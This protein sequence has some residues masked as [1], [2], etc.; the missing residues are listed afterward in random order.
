MHTP[1]SVILKR[2]RVLSDLEVEETEYTRNLI[3]GP[4]QAWEALSDDALTATFEPSPCAAA[5]EAFLT[6][7][8]Q[9]YLGA[10]TCL[11]TAGAMV[12]LRKVCGL[13]TCRCGLPNR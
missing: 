8:P 11:C 6:A 2:L 4:G 5:L 9:P 3:V 10:I 7:L 1:L 13:P 12:A